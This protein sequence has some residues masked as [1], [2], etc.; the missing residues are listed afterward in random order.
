MKTDA[1]KKA[2]NKWNKQHMSTIACS[3]KKTYAEQFKQYAE[4][5]GTTP[6]TILREYIIELLK[7]NSLDSSGTDSTSLDNDE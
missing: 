7:R 1:Q 2:R 3:L 6:S 5:H 4:E